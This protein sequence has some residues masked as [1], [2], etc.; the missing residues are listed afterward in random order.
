[1][2][3]GHSRR[4]GFYG[5]PLVTP[6]FGAPFQPATL[7]SDE[8]LHKYSYGPARGM[9]FRNTPAAKFTHANIYGG[10]GKLTLAA[11]RPQRDPNDHR[12]S[13]GAGGAGAAVFYAG[14][15]GHVSVQLV[16]VYVW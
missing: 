9:G 5:Q 14:T 16:A 7:D 2:G 8:Y 4:G 6:L 10:A 3:L 1:M 15:L 11:V 12:C 13:S